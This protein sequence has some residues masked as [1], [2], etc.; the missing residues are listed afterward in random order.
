MQWFDGG[1]GKSAK[2]SEANW[3]TTLPTGVIHADIFPA[4]VFFDRGRLSGIM[5]FYFACN[6]TVAYDIAICLNAWCFGKDGRFNFTK[7][8]L[9][10]G[11]N[12][13]VR[14]L[15]TNELAA[16]PLLAR[17]TEMRFFL[18]RLFDWLTPQDNALVFRKDPLDYLKIEG[19]TPI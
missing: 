5:D 17:G 2:L 6:D 19:F 11:A 4:N 3:L 1:I 10:L 12:S 14:E 8:R 16:L 9:F 15:N 7:A 13:R 18:T